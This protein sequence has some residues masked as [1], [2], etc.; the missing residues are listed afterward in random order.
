M[1][2]LVACFR[3]AQ[4]GRVAEVRQAVQAQAATLA[5]QFSGTRRYE[6]LQGRAKSNLYVDLIEW[7]D[8]QAF[9]AARGALDTALAAR[10]P[11]FLR[12]A[13]LCVYQA[14]GG[15]RLQQRQPEAVGVGLIRVRPGDEEAYAQQMCDLVRTR[16][17]EQ[18]GLITAGVYQ[19]RAAPRQFLIRNTWETAEALSAHQRWITHA[20]FPLTDSLVERREILAL[21]LHWSY[22]PAPAS[23][24]G[25]GRA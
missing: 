9:E 2:L 23:V 15:V 20:L 22:Q 14:R 12:P 6:V 25:A 5:R 3:E 7:D 1:S 18:P 24:G 13:H 11:L 10:Q 21:L 4:P 16:F 8:P 19:D 17:P